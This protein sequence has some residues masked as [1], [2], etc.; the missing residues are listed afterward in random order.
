MG[1]IIFNGLHLKLPSKNIEKSIK[2]YK[3]LLNNNNL[4]NTKIIDLTSN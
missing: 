3:K 2:I 1:F 4:I